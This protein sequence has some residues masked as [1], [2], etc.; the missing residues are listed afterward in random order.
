MLAKQQAPAAAAVAID[1][2]K[3]SSSAS[4]LEA[5][6]FFKVEFQESKKR[7]PLS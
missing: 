6:F 2:I 4:A 1:N 5:E 7:F 3:T